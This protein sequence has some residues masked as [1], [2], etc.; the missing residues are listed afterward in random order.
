MANTSLPN[1]TE[2]T[3]T[4]NTD[5]IHV[6]SGGTDYKETKANFLS[7]VNSSINS[8]NNSLT[9][10]LNFFK[11]SGAW[12]EQ[13]TDLNDVY[14]NIDSNGKMNIVRYHS[15]ST[16]TSHT[17]VTGDGICITFKASA[18]YGVQFV[19]CNVGVYARYINQGIWGEWKRISYFS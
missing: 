13:V 17:P 11:S 1:L 14:S 10:S 6:N 4:A 12:P 18:P 2:R 3:A 8:L 7:D 19:I 16:S 15:S 5:L 9:Q